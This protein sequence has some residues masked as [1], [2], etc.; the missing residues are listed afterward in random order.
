MLMNL[1]TAAKALLA[2]SVD[3]T[4]CP[5]RAASMQFHG[6]FVSYFT[7]QNDI[8]VLLKADLSVPEK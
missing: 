8:W 5:E 1:A 6:F 7:H 3:S 4:K 2:C